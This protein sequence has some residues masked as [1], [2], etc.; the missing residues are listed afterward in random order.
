MSVNSISK[1]TPGDLMRR[2]T[3]DTATVQGFITGTLQ[4]VLL[5]LTSLIVVTVIMFIVNWRLT[6]WAFLP[7][8]FVALCIVMYRRVINL[9][10]ESLWRWS[11]R[12]NSI[13]YDIIRRAL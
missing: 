12:S 7:V 2:I 13:L 3:S 5:Q 11:S 9:K 6:L 10:Y 4:T 1:R 8:P